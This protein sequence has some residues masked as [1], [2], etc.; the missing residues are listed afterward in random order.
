M[1]ALTAME[2]RGPTNGIRRELSLLLASRDF[3][4]IDATAMRLAGLEPEKARHVVEAAA[5]N[6]GRI[7][8][9]EIY[10]NMDG[11]VPFAP[12]IPARREWTLEMMNY[13]TRYRPFVYH[14]LLN[15]SLFNKA[16]GLVTLL[17]RWGLS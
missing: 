7:E 3:V 6:I 2:G 12:F 16:K 9:R 8:E 14:V 10:V 15:D 11:V 17:R 4:A 1:D 13:L 5:R